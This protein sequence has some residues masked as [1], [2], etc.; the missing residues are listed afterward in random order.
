MIGTI[1]SLVG[2]AADA[3]GL[4]D[5]GSTLVRGDGSQKV[6]E[7]LEDMN[8]RIERLSDEILYAPAVA[9]VTDTTK[10]SQSAVTDLR[11]VNY[12]TFCAG[13]VL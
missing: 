12:V 10:S 7:K 8:A 13:N 3:T 11:E 2:L 1:L 6:L 4:Y 9:G 5:F